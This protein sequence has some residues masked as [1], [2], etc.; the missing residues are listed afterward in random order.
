MYKNINTA[1]TLQRNLETDPTLVF[2]A[3]LSYNNS[4]E[5][6]EIDY[7]EIKDSMSNEN[8]NLQDYDFESFASLSEE[9]IELVTTHLERHAE[10]VKAEA[11]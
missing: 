10:T 6:L 11:M 8:V 3:E 4:S 7:W 2:L 5:E 9:I 1:T